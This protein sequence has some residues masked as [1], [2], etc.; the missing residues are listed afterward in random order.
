MPGLLDLGCF[1]SGT[2]DWAERVAEGLRAG[3]FESVG[4][5]PT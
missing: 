1:P 2:D 3:G 5:G 4:A